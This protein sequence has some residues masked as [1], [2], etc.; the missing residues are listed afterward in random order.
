MQQ[1]VTTAL[2][3]LPASI[4]RSVLAESAPA[5]IEGQPVQVQGL[6]DPGLP[7]SAQLDR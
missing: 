5:T 4:Q 6:T 2:G 3:G 1:A 7:D